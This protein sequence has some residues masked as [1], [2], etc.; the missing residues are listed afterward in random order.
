[1]IGAPTGIAGVRCLA[2]G[3]GVALLSATLMG[4]A[5]ISD[6]TAIAALVAPGKFDLYSCQ[7][8]EDSAKAARLRRT[9]L[10][11]LMARSAQGPGGEFVNAIAYR[12][13]YLQARGDLQELAKANT[14]KQCATKSRWSSQRALF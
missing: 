8:I 6:Q 11:Q 3:V 7:D 12:N 1:M 10:E 4:C 5:G 2:G 13:E 9:E 14:D